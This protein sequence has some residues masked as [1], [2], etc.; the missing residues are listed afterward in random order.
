MNY[1]II[2][3]DDEQLARKLLKSYIAIVDHLNLIGS[4]KSPIE[5][6]SVLKE[7]KIDII[8]LDIRM[9]DISGLDF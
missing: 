5:A 2:I 1:N 8:L 6:L 3:I 7:K 9:P 4:F